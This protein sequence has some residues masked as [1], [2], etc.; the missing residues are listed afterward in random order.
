MREWGR[1]EKDDEDDAH[2]EIPD[3]EPTLIMQ[4]SSSIV[5]NLPHVGDENKALMHDKMVVGCE[6]GIC[7]LAA[8]ALFGPQRLVGWLIRLCC[9]S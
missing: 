7:V 5:W 4:K 2:E 3:T 6:E 9:N 1:E 8:K